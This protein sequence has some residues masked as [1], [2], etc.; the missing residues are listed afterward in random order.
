MDNMIVRQFAQDID[1]LVLENNVLKKQ[2]KRTKGK[3]FIFG[4]SIIV[5]GVEV[6]LLNKELDRHKEIIDTY[7]IEKE[8]E[9]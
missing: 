6:Y 1:R 3:L 7:E 8:S 2:M 5:L 9:A 4:A